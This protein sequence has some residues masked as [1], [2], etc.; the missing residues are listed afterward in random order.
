MLAS[1]HVIV[2]VVDVSTLA[3]SS[4]LRTEK[5]SGSSAS[6]LWRARSSA[7]I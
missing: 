6:S 2:V 5:S 3:I 1:N 4:R 7:V